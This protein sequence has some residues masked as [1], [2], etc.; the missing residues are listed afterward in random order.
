MPRT[1]GKAGVFVRQMEARFRK[2]RW[3][4][5][6]GMLAAA[7]GLIRISSHYLKHPG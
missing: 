2:T 4:M 5:L 7:L 3:A 1:A 6:I